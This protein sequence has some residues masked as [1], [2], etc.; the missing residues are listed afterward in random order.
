MES[1]RYGWGL[2]RPNTAGRSYA[3][4]LGRDGALLYE[5]SVVCGADDTLPTWRRR[6]PGFP[7][8]GRGGVALY[9]QSGA[10]GV[11]DALATWRRRVPGF[12]R[13]G[14]GGVA[15]YTQSVAGG[16]DDTLTSWRRGVLAPR[17]AGG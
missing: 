15:L 17:E 11:D 8:G 3:G 9:A 12:P 6:V 10:G 7:R 16:A 4:S 13:G 5:Y 1:S 14:G 2:R